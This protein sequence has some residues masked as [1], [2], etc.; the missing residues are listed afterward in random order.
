MTR[1]FEVMQRVEA[2]ERQLDA[3]RD[4]LADLRKL[5][6]FGIAI[7]P[8]P[9]VA[10]QAPAAATPAPSPTAPAQWP[11]HVPTPPRGP[12]MTDR[13]FA[14]LS[15]KSAAWILAWVGGLVTA[16]GIVL[17][18]ALAA[19][20]GWIGPEARV[21]AGA[22]ASALVFGAGIWLRRRFGPTYSSLAAVG[23]GIAGAYA[24]LLA[25]AALYYLLAD[26][27]ALLVAAAI[28]AVGLSASLAWRSE[29]VAGLGLIGA[30]LVPI[31]VVADGE[32]S[33]LGTSFVGLLLVAAGVVALR[34]RWDRLLA[35]AAVAAV[36]QIVALVT[37]GNQAVSRLA[38]LAAAFAVV[39]TCLGAARQRLAGDGLLGL[40]AS[41]VLAGAAVASFSSGAL[42]DGHARGFALL[43]V[44][45]ALAVPT[46]LLLARPAARELANLFAVVGLAIAAVAVA[47]LVSGPTL[48]IIWAAQ[49]G[50]LAWLAPRTRELRLQLASLGYLALALGHTLVVDAPPSDLLDPV[51]HPAAGLPAV[52]AVVMAAVA[53]AWFCGTTGDVPTRGVFAA[54]RPVLETLRTAQSTVRAV[55]VWSAA[56]LS[57]YGAALAILAIAQALGSS[58]EI[59]F[60][61]GQV[62][63][64]AL[65][66]ALALA[67][68]W[69]GTR[70]RPDLATA[71]WAWLLLTTLKLVVH[72]VG[73]LAGTDRALALLAVGGALALAGYASRS[74]GAVS[75]VA[76]EISAPLA[77]AGALELAHGQL[78]G[79]DAD[80]LAL[81]VVAT[82]Y[83]A[84]ATASFRAAR[85]LSSLFWAVALLL[86]AVAWPVLFSGIWLA[87]AW[88]ATGAAL[89]GLA[90]VAGERRFLL[91]AFGYLALALAHALA[92]D[93]KPDDLFTAQLHPAAGVP[94]LV[95]WVAAAVVT[96]VVAG[97]TTP[98]PR[99]GGAEGLAEQLDDAQ[100]ALPVLMAWAVAIL[101]MFACS[102]AILELAQAVSSG[103]LETDFERGH[104][105]VSAF[106]GVVGLTLLYV[107]LVGRSRVL[108]LAGFITFGVTV[109][110]IF[111]YDLATL[112]AMARALSFLG[113]GAVLLLGGFFY[114][115]LTAQLDRAATR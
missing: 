4:E 31:A 55:L 44:A 113:V 15:R 10:P 96:A 39:L 22:L 57:L 18:F 23:A 64:D 7:A 86:L 80:G 28:A 90:L 79:L 3:L 53:A 51:V 52:A 16:L 40:S 14:A 8:A 20:R 109:G 58:Q 63:V 98:L 83:G 21:L 49:A 25:A 34:L 24:T 94:A 85:D 11:P 78:A 41:L 71:G 81:L 17:F 104:V 32:L 70:R 27:E 30:M 111:L 65:W 1:F 87:L 12:T 48:A 69:V 56:A 95:F 6:A 60:A 102:L 36:P 54:M 112:S 33:F 75:V 59:A 42:F 38:A 103:T 45:G 47:D 114:Q 62:G 99:D 67:A 84:L 68:V 107:G 2:A 19:N 82:V 73:V 5:A 35:A 9:P 72:D 46:V 115:R 74:F 97:R 77:T 26:W 29:F 106:W 76:V 43:V 108:R 66:S 13:A 92:I 50:V 89:A 100:R 88:S 61:R 101:S 91:A 110:K 105:A 93:A 37:E